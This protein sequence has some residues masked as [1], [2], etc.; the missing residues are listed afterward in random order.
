MTL[1][2]TPTMSAIPITIMGIASYIFI[3]IAVKIRDT[4]KASPTMNSI[5]LFIYP[6][7]MP[8]LDMFN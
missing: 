8:F 1:R 5:F 2:Y 3:S 7:S 6:T 4:R